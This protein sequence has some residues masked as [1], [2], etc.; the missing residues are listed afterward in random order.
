MFLFTRTIILFTCDINLFTCNISLLTSKTT[1]VVPINLIN[2]FTSRLVVAV[3]SAVRTSNVSSMVAGSLMSRISRVR[4]P[5]EI[6][7]VLG[8][9][10]LIQF[11]SLSPRMI[12]Y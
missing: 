12:N 9:S 10:K 7:T 11:I 3:C 6:R 2:A 5:W 1:L 8:A 4:L